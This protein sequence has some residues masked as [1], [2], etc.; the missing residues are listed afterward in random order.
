MGI[1]LQNI[2][3]RARNA[4]NLRIRRWFALHTF[5]AYARLDVPTFARREVQTQLSTASDDHGQTVMWQTLRTATEHASLCTHFSAQAFVL[6]KALQGQKGGRL[7]ALI[8]LLSETVSWLSYR[9][10]LYSLNGGKEYICPGG[11]RLDYPDS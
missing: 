4:L 8:T 11:R 7:L 2:R 3:A 9:F 6:F 10:A 5:M 1:V